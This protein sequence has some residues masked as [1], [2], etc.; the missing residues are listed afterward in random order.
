VLVRLPSCK[1]HMSAKTF[2]F[3]AEKRLDKPKTWPKIDPSY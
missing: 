3:E 1:P 2:L